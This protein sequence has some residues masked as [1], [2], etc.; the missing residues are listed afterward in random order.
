MAADDDGAML[1]ELRE[2]TKWLRLLGFQAL[3]PIL[4]VTLR[5]DKQKLVYEYSDG[6]R[7]SREVARLAGVG[8]GSVVRMWSDWLAA[9]ICVE[10]VNTTGRAQHLVSLSALG[11]P[12]PVATGAASA[13][14]E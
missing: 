14:E 3:R 1:A 7:A 12:L 13:E 2:Q 5:T 10:A 11:I 8:A 4:E 9:G 6:L